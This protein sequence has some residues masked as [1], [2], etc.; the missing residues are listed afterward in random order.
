MLAKR[1]VAKQYRFRWRVM[2]GERGKELDHL[3][4]SRRSFLARRRR[5]DIDQRSQGRVDGPMTIPW[6]AFIHR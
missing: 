6:S 2:K 4:P 5:D 1:C 3:P